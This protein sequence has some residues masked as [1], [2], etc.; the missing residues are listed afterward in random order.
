MSES[1]PKATGGVQVNPMVA[2]VSMTTAAGQAHTAAGELPSSSACGI[3]VEQ[4]PSEKPNAEAKGNGLGVSA[5][6]IGAEGGGGVGG[7]GGEGCGEGG[8]GGEGCSAQPG[9]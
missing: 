8:V 5:Q 9:A 3:T 4:S 7:E 1:T 2:R 6:F